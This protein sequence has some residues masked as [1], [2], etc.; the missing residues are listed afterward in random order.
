M[1]KLLARKDMK[2]RLPQAEIP[3]GSIQVLQVL[4]GAAPESLQ[5]VALINMLRNG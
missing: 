3:V 5:G 4:I 1:L 2:L